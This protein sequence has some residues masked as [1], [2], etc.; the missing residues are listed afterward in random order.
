MLRIDETSNT[1]APQEGGFVAEA[2][3]ARD[4]LLSLIASGWQAFAAEIGQRNVVYVAHTTDPGVDML[5]FDQS[6]GRV[7]LVLV[8]ENG[9][10]L[11]GR[12]LLAGAVVSG[13]SASDL[14]G[15]G[16]VLSA[17][18]P[19]ESPRLIL[20]ASEWD[21]A[22][23]AAVE[24]LDRRHNLDVKAFRVGMMRF[25]SE[26]LLTVNDATSPAPAPSA[27]ADPASEFYAHIQQ[28]ADAPASDAPEAPAEAGSTPPPVSA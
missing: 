17:A 7:V 3:P 1:L 28:S 2:P 15:M 27:T 4:E 18:V 26:R 24:W 23:L 19:G 11:L 12:S 21:E 13:W 6:G 5:A 10:E 16:T 14:A 22:T 25:G 20:V 8:G 9:R